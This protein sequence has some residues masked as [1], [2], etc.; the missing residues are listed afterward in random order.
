MNEYYY[1]KKIK[2][3]FGEYSGVINHEEVAATVV[4]MQKGLNLSD[5][6]VNIVLSEFDGKEEYTDDTI[7]YFYYR[8]IEE[9]IYPFTLYRGNLEVYEHEVYPFNMP[10]TNS[11]L[12]AIE[13]AKNEEF[14]FE[15]AVSVAAINQWNHTDDFIHNIRGLGHQYQVL[16]QKI[17][18]GEKDLFN[19]T[20][21]ITLPSINTIKLDLKSDP[22][23]QQLFGV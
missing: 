11:V 22:I 5:T 9:F 20:T 2:A 14:T 8:K 17:C 4:E 16:I 3:A 6:G 12:Y 13:M 1:A 21:P 19:I 10:A 15:Y 18:E 7:E 23:I